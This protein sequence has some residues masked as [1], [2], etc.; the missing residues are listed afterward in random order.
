VT[1][2][3]SGD[4]RL[5]RGVRLQLVL[6]TGGIVL[7]VLLA[8][9]VILTLAVASSLAASGTAQ[10]QDRADQLSDALRDRPGRPN[11]PGRPEVGI[12]VGGRNA[13]TFAF[14]VPPSGEIIRPPNLDLPPELPDVA[15]IA[16]VRESG[17]TDVRTENAGG[18]PFRILSEPVL[19]QGTVYVV[20]VAQDITA[21]RQTLT[22]LIAVLAIGGLLAVLAALAAGA[23]VAR[24]AL[25]PI[26]D[27]LRRQRE[28]AADAS[29]ELR[30]PLA[31]VRA[32]AEHLQR[33][34][35]RPVREVGTAVDDI[36]AEVDHM[37]GLVEDLLL[38]ARSDSGAV[39][40][41]REPVELAAVATDAAAGLTGLA[42]SSGVA[43]AV[44]PEPVE[45][46]GD[47]ARLRQLVT[48]L[49]D[50]GIRHGPSGGTVTV[51]VRRDGHVAA[52]TVDDDGPG[53][54]PADRERV[55]D[56]FWRSPDATP[57]GT[58]LG[59]AIAAWIVDQHQGTIAATDRPGGGS[60]FVVRLPAS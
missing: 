10:L 11:G 6:W 27:A 54:P 25:V 30:T 36:T 24:R 46:K 52:L 23:L 26:R 34:P 44:D 33:N 4:A 31:V 42:A 53:I 18:T 38:L 35:D 16:A 13:G 12:A 28:F 9:G 1:V 5:L 15:S 47:P 32:S 39:E 2:A 8:L 43:L 29:H 45:V 60:R 19:S 55:F 37:T 20:Q 50:N 56:R 41:V 59:L 22:T 17:Q 49:V 57:G 58:G 21:E 14:V 51:T 40:L 3:H 48:I 7:V